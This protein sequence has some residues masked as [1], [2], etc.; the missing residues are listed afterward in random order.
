MMANFDA[1]VFN[2]SCE[3]RIATTTTLQALTMMNGRL[4]NEEAR[5]LA[6]RVTGEVGQDRATQVRRMFEIVFNRR[7]SAVEV[8]RFSSFRGSLDGISRVLLN[9]NEAFYME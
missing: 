1:P 3:R 6:A 8:E 7:P 5:H 4:V 2:E 9:A